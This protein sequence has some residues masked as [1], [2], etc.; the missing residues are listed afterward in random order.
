MP[1][2]LRSVWRE[3]PDFGR[4]GTTT[5][6]ESGVL[7]AAA[8]LTPGRAKVGQPVELSFKEYVKRV[9]P[10][11]IWYD[12]CELVAS[13]LQDV[14]DDKKS[15]VM[16][17][18]PPRHSKTEE[19]SRLFPAYFLGR[20]P[21]RWAGINSYASEL[22]SGISRDARELFVRGGGAIAGDAGTIRNW[23]TIGPGGDA[24]GGLWCAGVGGAI[25][26]K[27]FHFG[28]IDDPVKNAEEAASELIGKRNQNWYRSTFYTRAE[29]GAAICVVQ[30]RWPGPGDLIG[31]LL[32]QEKLDE[33]QPERWHIVSLEAIKEK[34][35]IQVPVTCTLEPDKRAEGDALCPA[36]YPLER[37]QRIR[38]KLT[39]FYWNALFQQRPIPREGSKFKRHWFPIIGTMPHDVV[40]EVR[41]WDHAATEGGGDWTSGSRMARTASGLFIIRDVVRG[42]WSSGV[43]DQMIK[44]TAMLDGYEIPQEAEQEGGSGG[45][46]Q[47][48]SFRKL[49]T[50]FA[51]ETKPS[52]G[53]KIIRADPFASA[54]EVS[55]V[56][57]L[58][59]DWN[60]MVLNELT[61]FPYGKHDDVVDTLAA[62]FN[63][64]SQTNPMEVW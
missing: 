46:D 51:T 53:S 35:P 62:A 24:A 48:L 3:H 16:F 52:S 17:A 37:L 63:R 61:A 26:G 2:G 39:P 31:W 56:R 64:L 22:A 19:I 40:A 28:L 4:Q 15:R 42:Q 12:H 41:M 43:R 7:A 45:K 60:E 9:R 38:S 5:P 30:T 10:S 20:H 33:E 21:D 29:P 27:G 47:A 34:E 59:G 1:A 49:L 44:Q 55:N 25:T 11:F 36:R 50:G 18:M 8:R 23:R 58:K 13:V 57:M 14:A 54:A 6:I 32:E